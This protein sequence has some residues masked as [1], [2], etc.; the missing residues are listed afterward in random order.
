[1]NEEIKQ[2]VEAI[3]NLNDKYD[4]LSLDFLLFKQRYEMA[5]SRNGAITEVA[6]WSAWA[7]QFIVA[8]V[9]SLAAIVGVRFAI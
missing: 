7:R 5:R 3:G 9:A 1:M 6:T 8:L 4:A 2:L